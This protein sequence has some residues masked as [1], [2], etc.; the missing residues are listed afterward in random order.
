MAQGL[1]FLTS[2]TLEQR[3]IANRPTRESKEIYECN[4]T[5]QLLTNTTQK[6]QN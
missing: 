3:E 5:I 4:S 2:N 1:F 6:Y